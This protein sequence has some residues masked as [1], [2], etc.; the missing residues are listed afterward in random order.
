MYCR[1][2]NYPNWNWPGQKEEVNRRSKWWDG[3]L[4]E[5]HLSPRK[6]K[7]PGKNYDS[8]WKSKQKYAFLPSALLC[9]NMRLWRVWQSARNKFLL[10]RET[11]QIYLGRRLG[12]PRNMLNLSQI[13][14]EGTW[15]K[16]RKSRHCT[17]FLCWNYQIFLCVISDVK[18]H[19]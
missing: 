3:W 2:N 8:L 1:Q 19:T 6:E 12:S 18:I 14:L 16:K 15:K 5:S 9:G 4:L 13:L 10:P 11:R 7:K 17:G